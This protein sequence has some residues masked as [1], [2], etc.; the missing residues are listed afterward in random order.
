MTVRLSNRTVGQPTYCATLLANCSAA[1]TF[2]KRTAPVARDTVRAS[3]RVAWYRICVCCEVIP[4]CT[5]DSGTGKAPLPFPLSIR[6]LNNSA[7]RPFVGVF[8]PSVVLY[9]KNSGR[10]S[11]FAVFLRDKPADQNRFIMGHNAHCQ[12]RSVHPA[13]LWRSVTPTSVQVVC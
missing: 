10:I 2:P 9:G 4:N 13:P 8:S 3:R 12:N 11:Y 5:A 1:R 6:Q 7:D